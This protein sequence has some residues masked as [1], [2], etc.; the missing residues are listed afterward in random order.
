M[1]RSLILCYHDITSF[2][3]CLSLIEALFY[4]KNQPKNKNKNY[5]FLF[6]TFLTVCIS[7]KKFNNLLLAVW[8]IS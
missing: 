6:G 4:M 2:P 3:S 8:P 7:I 5:R 1:R